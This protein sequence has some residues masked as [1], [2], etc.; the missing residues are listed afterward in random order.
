[1]DART[2]LADTI[3]DY[4]AAANRQDPGAVAASFG[5]GAT[6]RDEG[7]T[8]NGVAAIRAWAEEVS[9][10]Y[11]PTVE[12]LGAEAMVGGTVV[13]GRVSGNFPGSPVELRYRFTLAGGKIARLEIG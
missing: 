2:K 9:T 10:K 1:M 13:A 5:D 7:E 11:Q 3:T 6:V 12:V 4:F 8:R